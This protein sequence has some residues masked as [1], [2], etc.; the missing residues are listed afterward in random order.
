MKERELLE[1]ALDALNQI[2]DYGL[3][4]FPQDTHEELM[5]E[6]KSFLLEESHD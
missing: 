3:E 5:D 6:I 2:W 4:N 1:R